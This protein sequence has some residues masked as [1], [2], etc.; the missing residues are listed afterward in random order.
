[1]QGAGFTMIALLIAGCAGTNQWGEAPAWVNE[2]PRISSDYIGIASAGKTPFDS[3][4]FATAQKRALAELAGQIRVKIEASSI[5]H[6]TQFQGIAGQNFEERIQSAATEDLEGYELVGRYENETEIWA[7]Y[8]LNKATYQRIL[9]ERKA[10]DL[11]I[12]GGHFESALAAQK[13]GNAAL[14]MDG[15]IRCLEDLETHWGEVNLWQGT[16]G[17]IALD[18]AARD[19]I[20]RLMGDM[21]LE[22][23]VDGIKL[24]FAERY[25]GTLVCTAT[26]GNRPLSKVPIIWRYNRGTLPKSDSGKTNPSGEITIGLSQFEPGTRNSELKI[27]LDLEHLAPRIAESSAKDLLQHLPVPSLSIPIQLTPPTIYFNT[28]EKQKGELRDQ[29]L[30]LNSIAEGLSNQGVTWV[31]RKQEADLI[32]T[33]ESDTRDSGSGSG[34][35]TAFLN[36]TVVLKTPDGTPILQQNLNDIKG[37]H[38]SWETAHAEAYRKATLE[39]KGRF[40]RQL[41]NALYQ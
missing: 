39:I 16:G 12:A 24:S 32:L 22:A 13:Q 5:L 8:R 26:L 10:A 31:Q 35:Y 14:A 20:S 9:S 3:D 40:L 15:Y 25:R 36:A 17:E 30:L 33:L 19:G 1:M 28:N 4:A 27:E 21:H 41:V 38:N 6:T 11:E 2:R 34:F 37:V 18:R 23:Q 7:Y 29:Q